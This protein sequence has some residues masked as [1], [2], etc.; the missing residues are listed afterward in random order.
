VSAGHNEKRLPRFAVHCA[1]AMSL[2]VA[3][4][5]AWPAAK[6]KLS[7]AQAD[8][9]RERARCTRGESGQALA[10]CLKEANAAYEEA[11][12][13]RLGEPSAAD[14]ARNATQRCS[15]Q[16]PA[17][18]PDCIQRILGVGNAEGSVGGGGVIRR[19]ESGSN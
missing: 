17:D 15:A 7:Q 8:L 1:I 10:T 5:P 9:Q 16:P 3:V 19:S 6:G 2:A 18:R 11:R 12:H 4:V 14:L 13:G